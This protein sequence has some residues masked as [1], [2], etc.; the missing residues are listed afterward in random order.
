[1]TGSTYD[2]PQCPPDTSEQEAEQEAWERYAEDNDIDYG[3]RE[4]FYAWRAD[5]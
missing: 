3:D 4:A 2:P 5:R 1:M